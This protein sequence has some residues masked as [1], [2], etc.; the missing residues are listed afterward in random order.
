MPINIRVVGNYHE[1]GAF[2]ADVAKMS[3]IVTLSELSIA[4]VNPKDNKS[5][6]PGKLG[7]EAIAKTYRALDK[8]EAPLPKKKGAPPKKDGK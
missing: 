4:N 7:M 1:L 3:R 5:A 2:A 8:G 6:A